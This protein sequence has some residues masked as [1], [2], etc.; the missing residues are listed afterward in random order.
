MKNHKAPHVSFITGFIAILALGT[1]IILPFFYPIP[2][3][4]LSLLYSRAGPILFVL[5][6]SSFYLGP[7]AL[8]SGI[9]ALRQISKGVLSRGKKRIALIGTIMGAI[10]TSFYLFGFV[11]LFLI[12]F[13]IILAKLSGTGPLN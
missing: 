2:T 1:A 13:K 7:V 4:H 11:W 12:F 8:Y 10:V 5:V 9:L 3:G 6:M